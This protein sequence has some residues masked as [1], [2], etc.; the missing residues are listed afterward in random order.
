ML[1][2]IVL[3]VCVLSSRLFWTSGL[4]T[5]QPGSHRNKVTQDFSTF[6]LRALAS[7]LL[8]RRSQPFLSLVDLEVVFLCANEV[9]VLHFLDF[10]FFFVRKNP[11]SCDCPEIRTHVQTSEGFE[12]TDC[13]TGATG[14]DSDNSGDYI[15]EELCK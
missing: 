9:I 12:V 3:C 8:A 2:L 7:Q 10:F 5:Y 11:S 4:W 6:L 14:L 15:R 1:P 13:T